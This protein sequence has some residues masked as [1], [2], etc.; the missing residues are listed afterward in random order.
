MNDDFLEDAERPSWLAIAKTAAD[1]ARDGVP[2]VQ[3]DIAGILESMD[4]PVIMFGDSGSF[5]SWLALFICGAILR[6]APFLGRA[7]RRRPFVVYVNFD[8]GR[9]ALERRIAMLGIADENFVI[10]SPVDGWDENSFDD[11]LAHYPGAFVVIDCFADI[12]APDSSL[13]QYGGQTRAFLKRL[14]AIYAKHGAN[15]LLIDHAK[16]PEGARANRHVGAASYIGSGQKKAATR[17]MWFIDRVFGE[18]DLP[19]NSIVL[20]SAKAN[21]IEQ[22]API[23]IGFDFTTASVVSIREE[24]APAP[25]AHKMTA[26]E[27][28]MAD[29]IDFVRQHGP[30]TRAMLRADKNGTGTQKR[31]LSK[32]LE[33]G[34]LIE[35]GGNAVPR[36][37]GIAPNDGGQNDGQPPLDPAII[38]EEPSNDERSA[39]AKPR[40]HLG[41][42]P[43][44]TEGSHAPSTGGESRLLGK[45]GQMAIPPLG[46]G[47][48]HLAIA[49]DLDE[50]GVTDLDDETARPR[51]LPASP[52]SGAPRDDADE[53]DLG[54]EVPA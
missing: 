53:L 10:V 36:R 26:I 54:G 27:K 3:M 5:K 7:T 2:D 43:A 48:G 38:G 37:Y 40:G 31:A 23:R 28:A 39:M 18:D 52:N 49:H 29:Q 1:I 44:G 33:I 45:G 15:G 11:L 22:F 32:N 41:H 50:M 19:T 6:G 21:D 46:V 30:A 51:A 35:V 24:S 47:H 12:F 4:G 20:G 34:R 9:V 42:H 17:Q 8:S 14:R 16:R 13:D 25:A